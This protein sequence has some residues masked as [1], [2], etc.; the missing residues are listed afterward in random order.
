MMPWFTCFKI[1]LQSCQLDNMKT[2]DEAHT[3]YSN[4][5]AT[6]CLEDFYTTLSSHNIKHT[7]T[8]QESIDIQNV[9]L[10][11]MCLYF[12]GNVPFSLPIISP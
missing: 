4:W 10:S 6:Q 1:N 11:D 9:S 12:R 8:N 7:N 2:K 3:K 5:D